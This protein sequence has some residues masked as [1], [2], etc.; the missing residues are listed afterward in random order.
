M[1]FVIF[2][3]KI[4]SAQ[5][6]QPPLLQ[7]GKDQSDEKKSSDDVVGGE[8]DVHVTLTMRLVMQIATASTAVMMGVRLLEVERT[9]VELWIHNK[10]LSHPLVIMSQKS[11]C[12]YPLS[13][14]DLHP[15]TWLPQQQQKTI[16]AL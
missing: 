9:L 16:Q 15:T 14:L 6:L 12:T 3:P 13:L 5:Q 1:T 8:R 2:T 11:P 4:I 10:H 7:V